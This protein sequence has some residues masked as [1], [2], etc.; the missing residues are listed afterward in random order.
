MPEEFE[1]DPRKFIFGPL[2]DCLKCGKTECGVFD[3]GPGRYERLC[4]NCRASHRFK[5]PQIRKAIVYLDQFAISNLSHV[6]TKDK[7]V[8]QFW[9][10]VYAKLT[11]LHI[12]QLIVC[13][14]SVAHMIESETSARNAEFQASAEMFAHDVFFTDFESIRHAIILK[15]LDA[16]LAAQAVVPEVTL[17]EICHGNPHGWTKR[18]RLVAKMPSIPGYATALRADRD[19]AHAGLVRVFESKW[20]KGGETWEHWYDEE[21]RA[22]G[23]ETIQSYNRERQKCEDVVSGKRKLENEF[24]ALVQPVL[25]LGRR[26]CFKLEG[27]GVGKDEVPH[28]AGEFLKSDLLMQAHFCNLLSWCDKITP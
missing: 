1:F 27:S 10:D 18:W 19:A 21:A 11:H 7:V 9:Q 3:V 22:Y 24:D 28:R 15:A 26:I 14:K 6:R 8:D 25:Q 2:R 16:W 17:H 4:R 23:N 20:K 13:P 5:L 12:L